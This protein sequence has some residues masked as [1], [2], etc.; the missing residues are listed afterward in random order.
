MNRYELGALLL[1]NS[2]A[3]LKRSSSSF[4]LREICVDLHGQNSCLP[5]YCKRSAEPTKKRSNLKA[6]EPAGSI[7][8]EPT[9][10]IL[11]KLVDVLQPQDAT[12]SAFTPQRSLSSF[13]RVCSQWRQA[14][15]EG[16]VPCAIA[17][18]YTRVCCNTD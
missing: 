7:W 6:S 8:Q 2:V 1:A 9:A 4:D 17:V 11:W 5:V 16:L 18:C 10:E 14:A 12:V 3:N 15:R 13:K